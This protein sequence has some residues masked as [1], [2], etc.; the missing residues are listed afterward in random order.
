MS[1]R[2]P[3]VTTWQDSIDQQ[4]AASTSAIAI[5][6]AGQLNQLRRD[7]NEAIAERHAVEQELA[8]ALAEVARLRA[9]VVRGPGRYRLT[10]KGLA[11]T[12]EPSTEGA[13]K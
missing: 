1:D 3:A 4:M 6:L 13:P 7:Y 11:A 2:D 8:E 12:A 5:D 10:D 9:L